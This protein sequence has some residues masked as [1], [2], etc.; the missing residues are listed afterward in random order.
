M[1]SRIAIVVLL[2]PLFALFAC[3]QYASKLP[4]PSEQAQS[5]SIVCNM[6]TPASSSPR[7][8][9]LNFERAMAR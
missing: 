9:G 5:T 7:I 3:A 6:V 8:K 1:K 4:S 2:L